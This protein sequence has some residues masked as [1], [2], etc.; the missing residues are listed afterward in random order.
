MGGQE[1]VK[2]LE[3]CSVSKSVFFFHIFFTFFFFFLLSVLLCYG[4]ESWVVF[5]IILANGVWKFGRYE[6]IWSF[7]E[8]E[9]NLEFLAQRCVIG[10]PKSLFK[11]RFWSRF[12]PF[13][14]LNFNVMLSILD[15]H[16]KLKCNEEICLYLFDN[17]CQSDIK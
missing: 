4:V 13:S 5:T 16:V 11:R 6:T 10:F 15:E 7:S 2:H 9:R 1:N 3:E 8:P 12:F 14:E 17:Y